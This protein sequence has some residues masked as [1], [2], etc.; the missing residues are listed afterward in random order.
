MGTFCLLSGNNREAI[1]FLK[2]AYQIDSGNVANAYDLALAYRANGDISLAHDLAAKTLAKADGNAGL[3]ALLGDLD[4]RMGDPLG[5]VREYESAA[6][7]DPSEP[8][9][10]DWG[11]ELLLH[12]AVRPAVIVFRKGMTAHP[13]SAKL[14]V[15]LGAALYADG[16]YDEAADQLCRAIGPETGR[17]HAVS[18]PG[19]NGSDFTHRRSLAANRSWR[20]LC[21]ISPEMLWRTITSRWRS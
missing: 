3:H 8:N 14:R 15:G 12:R 11:S 1:P 6:T 17:Y 4:E 2:A 20:V 19:Q 18:L 13:N 5:A 21:S 16:S 10:F 9:Y 7:L